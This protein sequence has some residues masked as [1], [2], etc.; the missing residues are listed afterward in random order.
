VPYG[1]EEVGTVMMDLLASDTGQ[2]K[3]GVARLELPCV[4]NLNSERII[5]INNSSLDKWQRLAHKQLDQQFTH[6]IIHGLDCSPF[7]ASAILETVYRVYAPYFET[8]ATL[9]PGQVL[10]QVISAETSA[11]TPLSQ[12]KQVTVVLT[13]DAG[14]EDLKVRQN[15]GIQALR[16]HRMQRMCIEAFQQGGLLTIEDLAI[17]LFNCGQRTLSRDLDALRRQ[18]IVLPLRSTIKDMGRSISHRS[19]IIAQ[20]LNGK[21]YSEIARDTH[22]SICSVQNYIGKFKRVV[23]LAEEGYDIHTIAF[24][25]KVS[26]SLAESYHELYRRMKIVPH[27]VKELTSFLKKGTHQLSIARYQ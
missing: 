4:R 3:E 27:R 20:W 5:M 23:A 13:F 9:K 10:F 19:H 7:E 22:H 17:R 6:E 14:I 25:V 12:G 16:T 11:N 15:E 1:I 8:S 21:E 2:W 18:G 24:L 26:P